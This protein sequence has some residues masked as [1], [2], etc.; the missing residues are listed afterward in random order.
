MMGG[1]EDTDRE[2]DELPGLPQHLAALAGALIGPSD[3]GRNHDKH[4]AYR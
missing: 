3:L 2:R 1:H 4:L